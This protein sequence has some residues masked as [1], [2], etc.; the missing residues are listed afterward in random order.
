MARKSKKRALTEKQM[1]AQESRIPAVAARAFRNAFTAAIAS[2]AT[3]LIAQNGQL[4][5]V[6]KTEKTFLRSIEGYSS[7]KAGTRL[8]ITKKECLAQE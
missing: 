5:K 4:F 2:G 6:S 7:I 8:K 1:T 3:V